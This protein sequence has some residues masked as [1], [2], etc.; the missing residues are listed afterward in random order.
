MLRHAEEDLDDVSC[1]D[2]GWDELFWSAVDMDALSEHWMDE[3][4]EMNVDSS[5]E[6][7][8]YSSD[9]DIPSFDFGVL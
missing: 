3:D 8:A 5:K 9:D 2:N 7:D 6:V 1:E 4:R